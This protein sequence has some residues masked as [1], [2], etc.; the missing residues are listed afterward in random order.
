MTTGMPMQSSPVTLE[1]RVIPNTG[2][3]RRTLAMV[4]SG[5]ITRC[6][7]SR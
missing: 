3:I 1:R 5:A 6:V 7:P 4:A 2:I